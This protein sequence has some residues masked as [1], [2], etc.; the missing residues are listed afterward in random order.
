MAI[1]TWM[2]VVLVILVLGLWFYAD[3]TKD[4]VSA[5]GGVTASIGGKAVDNIQDS[6]EADTSSNEE[7]T[8]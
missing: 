3:T 1:K 5:V 7:D 8:S 6:G 2:I 4:V